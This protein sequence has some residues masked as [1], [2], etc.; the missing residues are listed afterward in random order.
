MMEL[1]I[2]VAAQKT[3]IADILAGRDAGGSVYSFSSYEDLH[4]TLTPKRRAIIDAMTGHGVLSMREVARFVGRDFKAVQ[5]D[6]TALV[7]I[8]LIDRA[9][10]GGGFILPYDSLRIDIRLPTNAA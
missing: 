5:G 9:K 3:V 6:I 4:R 7:N 8:G 10:A 2:N 1:K